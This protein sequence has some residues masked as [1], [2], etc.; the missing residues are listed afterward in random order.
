M[1]AAAG[2][3]AG[4]AGAE[5]PAP[6]S[7]ARK[8]RIALEPLRAPAMSVALVEAVEENLC[9]AIAAA[10][11]ADVVCPGDVAAMAVAA[12]EGAILG[13]CAT[14]ECLRRVDAMNDADRRVSGSLERG[15]GVLV[16]SLQVVDRAGPSGRSVEKLPEDLDGLF[17]RLPGAVRR[18][19]PQR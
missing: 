1:I 7:A 9:A 12:R 13:A 10:T 18:L 6:A 19:F 11:G 3:A 15:E 5:E 14:D 17:S 2:I 16:L 8:V 4:A